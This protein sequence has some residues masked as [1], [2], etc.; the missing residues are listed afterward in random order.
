LTPGLT[1]IREDVVIAFVKVCCVEWPYE[2][3]I[4]A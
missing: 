4:R 2:G 1:L 3:R